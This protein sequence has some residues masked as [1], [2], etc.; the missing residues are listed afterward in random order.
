MKSHVAT[1]HGTQSF[2]C[3]ICGNSFK[4]KDKQKKHYIKCK[5]KRDKIKENA[6][7][8]MVDELKKNQESVLRNL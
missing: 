8:R 7:R 3:A 1:V 4:T 2:S 5:A 6:M